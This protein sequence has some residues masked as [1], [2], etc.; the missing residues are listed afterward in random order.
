MR[1]P[2]TDPVVP[3]AFSTLSV[4]VEGA[5]ALINSVGIEYALRIALSH[6]IDLSADI[7]SREYFPTLASFGFFKT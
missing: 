7:P 3:S 2:E 4:P 6:P 5:D 1:S